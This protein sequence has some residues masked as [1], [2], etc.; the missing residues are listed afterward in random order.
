MPEETKVA[1][2]MEAEFERAKD[3]MRPFA[4]GSSN[5]VRRATDVPEL[6]VQQEVVVSTGNY[7]ADSAAARERERAFDRGMLND[8]DYLR[9]HLRAQE[10]QYD[11]QRVNALVLE[12]KAEGETFEVRSEVVANEEATATS[13]ATEADV[14]VPK[15][16]TRQPIRSS[17]PPVVPV[18][19]S[20]ISERDKIDSEL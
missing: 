14:D 17:S 2:D 8:D 9:R 13:G 18:A 6:E 11:D 19:Q 4:N 3:A 7:A 10:H 16:G 15:S 20:F 1:F 5:E 12:P